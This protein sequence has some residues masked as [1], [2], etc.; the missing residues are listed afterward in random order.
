MIAECR[1]LGDKT[2]V[3]FPINML[4]GVWAGENPEERA[5]RRSPNT[6]ILPPPYSSYPPRG[7]LRCGTPAMYK[8]GKCKCFDCSDANTYAMKAYRRQRAEGRGRKRHFCAFEKANRCAVCKKRDA[9]RQMERRKVLKAMRSAPR[10]V[11]CSNCGKVETVTDGRSKRRK[12]CSNAC[13][14]SG[15]NAA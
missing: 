2:E 10:L 7:E 1:A 3:G 15:R 12:Y 11:I 13:Q 9:K 4:Q 14:W 6:G 8:S 5:L